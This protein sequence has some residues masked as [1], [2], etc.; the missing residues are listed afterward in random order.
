MGSL[1][2]IMGM[3]LIQ[4]YL[5]FMRKVN[6]CVE[7]PGFGMGHIFFAGILGTTLYAQIFSLFFRVNM[8]A[9]ILLMVLSFIYILWQKT[10]IAT[11][12]RFPH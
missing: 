4:G 12:N 2:G 8:E 10:F 6:K 3:A 7:N 5:C 9:N 11:E 1:V